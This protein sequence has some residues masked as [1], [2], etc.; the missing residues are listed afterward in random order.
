LHSSPKAI[1]NQRYPHQPNP[2]FPNGQGEE[3]NWEKLYERET[4]H[5]EGLT[6]FKKWNV[7]LMRVNHAE[8][9]PRAKNWSRC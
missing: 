8:K 5:A 7:S 4:Q 2:A 3:E 1:T 9:G 6:F